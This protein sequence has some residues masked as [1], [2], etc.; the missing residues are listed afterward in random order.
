MTLYETTV[1]VDSQLEDDA[2]R[3]KVDHYV[4]LLVEQGAEIVNLDRRGVRKLAYDIKGKDGAWR[5]QADYTF[6]LF[7]APGTAISPIEALLR[8]DEDIL[9]FMTVR[10]RHPVTSMEEAE[11]VRA[12]R[13]PGGARA[14]EPTTREGQ[15][16]VPP[17]E[18]KP[19]RSE[20]VP[21]E[22]AVEEPTEE[23]E[24]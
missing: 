5:N 6:I 15:E 7:E 22:P 9:R 13:L 14:D 23:Q 24:N 1:V 3:G 17:S 21:Q 20:D 4:N 10:P 12:A 19:A 2:V 18:E 11:K 16:P 8:L